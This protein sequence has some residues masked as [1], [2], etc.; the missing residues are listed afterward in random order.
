MSIDSNILKKILVKK[1]HKHK[2]RKNIGENLWYIGLYKQILDLT[3]KPQ[4]IKGKIDKL[5]FIKVK[6]N[7]VLWKIQLK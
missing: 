4:T 6:K 5:E 7:L 1:I 3:L 2:T